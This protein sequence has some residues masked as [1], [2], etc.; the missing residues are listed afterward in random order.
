MKTKIQNLPAYAMNYKY[1]VARFV[2]N[3]WWFWGS[4]NEPERAYYAAGVEGGTVFELGSF[5]C[6]TFVGDGW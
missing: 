2:D 4:Y 3:E 6:G 1:T 5:E